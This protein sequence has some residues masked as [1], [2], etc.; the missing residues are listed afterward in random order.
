MTAGNGF[1]ALS[2]KRLLAYDQSAK[3]SRPLLKIKIET[4]FSRRRVELEA[5]ID[6]GFSGYLLL[7]Q[8]SYAGLAESELPSDYFLTYS[9]ICTSVSENAT[10]ETPEQRDQSRLVSL[11]CYD[12][13]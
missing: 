13:T 3:P 7:P 5:P 9:T 2:G 10:W 12:S 11:N 6:T 4:P 8:E 1:G